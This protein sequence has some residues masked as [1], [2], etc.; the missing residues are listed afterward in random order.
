MSFLVQ[1]LETIRLNLVINVA[2]ELRLVALLIVVGK[3]L[4]VLGNVT[5]EDVL[6]QSLRVQLLSLNVVTWETLLR[7]RNVETA[8]RGTLHG[9]KD[10]STGA[11]AGET[12]V[13][14]DLEWAAGLAINLLWLGFGELAISLLNAGE[15]V[16]ELELVEGATGDEQ[17]DTVGS[18]PVGE[19]VGDAVAL[20]LVAVGSD[21]DL[22]A[23]EL[24]GD[25][26]GDDVPVGEADDQAVL[27]RIV[28]VLGLGDEAL[29]SVVVGLTRSATLV[30]DLVSADG[31]R[32]SVSEELPCPRAVVGAEEEGGKCGS[33]DDSPEVGAVLDQLGL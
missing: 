1:L 22:V 2:R 21:K 5:S 23:G 27:W 10:T 31:G 11:G 28:L 4:H 20:Q 30:L 26:L 32:R 33:K 8:V 9:A 12:D 19:T 3:S 13:E 18:G 16:L 6:A 25:D 7:V 17:T 14:E 15:G 29:A 24:R